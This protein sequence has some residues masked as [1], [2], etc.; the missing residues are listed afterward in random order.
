MDE[1]KQQGTY[2]PIEYIS[3]LRIFATIFVIWLHTCSTL[4]E[5]R[6]YFGINDMQ[7]FF[8]RGVSD[9]VLGCSGISDDHRCPDAGKKYHI[10]EMPD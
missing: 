10:F 3:R 2:Y 4:A 9:Y 5:N 7:Y 8:F 6:E 1:V